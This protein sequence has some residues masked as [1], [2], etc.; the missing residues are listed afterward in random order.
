MK[1]LVM[2]ALAAVML[3]I[4]SALAQGGPPLVTDDPETPADG[5]WE[6]NIAAIYA[7]THDRK[8]LAL[9]DVDMNYGLGG[10]IQLKLDIPWAFAQQ[11]GNPWKSGVGAGDVGVK[12]R[13]IDQDKAGF[14]MSTYPQL[15]WNILDSS[16]NR[17]ITSADKQ[18]FLPL[19][20]ATEYHGVGLD[21]EFGR[22]FVQHGEDEW[23]LGGIVAP[24]CSE[25]ADC[26]FELHETWAPHQHT[27]LVN[28]GFHY[29]LSEKM[30][31]LGGTTSRASFPVRRS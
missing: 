18:F 26:L 5:H 23:V 10:H 27:T 28:V 17:G 25:K 20:A 19:E 1:K 29:T 4:G 13:F 8:D 22:N 7:R 11:G 31:L 9:P 14:S 30:T 6:I 21:A 2:A 12:W 24:K 3:P 16:A 15:T